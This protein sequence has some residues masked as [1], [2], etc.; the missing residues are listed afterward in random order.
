M[1]PVTFDRFI[2]ELHE[3]PSWDLEMSENGLVLIVNK[4]G[5]VTR[6]HS[7]NPK[8]S[9]GI[10]WEKFLRRIGEVLEKK[11]VTSR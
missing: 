2:T 7:P 8:D 4:E 3:A 1:E 11:E 6:Y 10:E 5:I 9:N